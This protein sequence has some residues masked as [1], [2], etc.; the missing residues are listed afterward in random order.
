[1]VTDDELQTYVCLMN[2]PHGVVGAMHLP[3]VQCSAGDTGPV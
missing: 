3:Q 1:M 2:L